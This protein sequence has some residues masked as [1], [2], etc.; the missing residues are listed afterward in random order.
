MKQKISLLKKKDGNKW[1]EY[2]NFPGLKT[3]VARET[4]T[5]L[6]RLVFKLNIWYSY[7]TYLNN[8]YYWLLL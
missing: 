7:Y 1:G 4:S 2:D 8:E 3:K 5:V 6:S